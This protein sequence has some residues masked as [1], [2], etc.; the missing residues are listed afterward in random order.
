MPRFGEII[1]SHQETRKLPQNSVKFGHGA[2]FRYTAPACDISL[3]LDHQ[4]SRRANGAEGRGLVFA[5]I[6]GERSRMCTNHVERPVL[7]PGRK[8]VL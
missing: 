4:Q 2:L 5:S 3:L 7:T 8:R 1:V 6:N